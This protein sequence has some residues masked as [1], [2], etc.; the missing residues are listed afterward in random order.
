[1]KTYLLLLACLFMTGCSSCRITPPVAT[2][3][4]EGFIPLFNGINLDGWNVRQAENRDWQVVDGVIDCNPHEGQGD[5]N[6]WT[7]ESYG[8]FELLV[9]W[10][11][12]DS[13]YIN[14]A[15]KIIL[16]DGT[17]KKDDYGKEML[18]EVKTAPEGLED[19]FTFKVFCLKKCVEQNALICVPQMRGYHL[20]EVP[21]LELL[22]D[23]KLFVHK[24]Y[25]GFSPNDPAVR[26]WAEEDGRMDMQEMLAQKLV[27]F[28]RW[29]PEATQFNQQHKEILTRER[30]R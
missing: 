25:R 29:S 1:M 28:K 9:D 14:R 11:I 6:L 12:K 10:R 4:P 30:Q 26:I 13:P 18:I 21:A 3:S 27:W 8:D 2:V 17:Y 20:F 19:F 5:R 7:I 22:L 24:I 16:P 15:G 23:K